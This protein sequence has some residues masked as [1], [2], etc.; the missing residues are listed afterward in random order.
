MLWIGITGPMGS[1]KSTVA[2]T[3]RQMGF[4]VLDADEV[5]R[6]ILGPGTPGEAEVLSTFGQHLQDKHGRLDRRALGRLVFNDR[7]KLEKL[8]TIIHPR[9]RDEVARLR[10][11]LAARGVVAA[12]YDVPLLFEKNMQDQF[13]SVLVVTADRALRDARVA[14]RSQLSAQEIAERNARQLPPEIKEAKASAVI[15]NNGTLTDLQSE[16]ARALAKI[17]VRLPGPAH[18]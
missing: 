8:E 5:A 2:H 10:G 15:R 14:T 11:A 9:V 18:S 17:G 1:G 16:I 12:F 13:D 4:E 7:V 3:L 6:K